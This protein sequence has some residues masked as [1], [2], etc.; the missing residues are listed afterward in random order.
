MPTPCL[1]QAEV[2]NH[3]W[4]CT[5]RLNN[6]QLSTQLEPLTM[7]FCIMEIMVL[8]QEYC[9]LCIFYAFIWNKGIDKYWI[10]LL[11]QMLNSTSDL[12]P[13]ILEA[14]QVWKGHQK[15]NLRLLLKQDLLQARH[16]FYWHTNSFKALM[17][18]I[19]AT[20]WHHNHISY[21]LY[22]GIIKNTKK[23]KQQPVQ[24]RETGKME[25]YNFTTSTNDTQQAVRTVTKQHT[26]Q[27]A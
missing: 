23:H 24:F 17:V 18:K 19:M 11:K 1:I 22:T 12:W 25:I 7:E 27:H 26:F 6:W 13:T 16:P 20:E 9:V 2:F 4:F 3:S 5:I 15:E 10:T 14:L 8:R 21:L